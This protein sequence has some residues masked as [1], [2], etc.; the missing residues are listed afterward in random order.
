MC[1]TSDLTEKLIFQSDMYSLGIILYELV[2]SF[3]TDME[4]VHSITDLRKGHLSP[5]VLSEFPQFASVITQL[6][7]RNPVDRPDAS[8]LLKRL[9]TDTSESEV[10]R[11]LKIQLAQKEDEIL[12]LKELLKAAGYET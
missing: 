9:T 2:C 10:V 7:A 12:R 6:M 3:K 11:D 8:T 1:K 4:R 5:Y